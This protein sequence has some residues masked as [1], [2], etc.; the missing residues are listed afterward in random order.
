M[1][2]KRTP[3][4]KLADAVSGILEGVFEKISIGE[5]NAM[6]QIN[7]TTW[8]TLLGNMAKSVLT[9]ASEETA[10]EL[11]NIIFDTIFMNELSEYKVAMKKYMDM[12]KRLGDK[13]YISDLEDRVMQI[14]Q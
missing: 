9:N 12:N 8:K 14:A 13:E 1:A 4:D 6:R 5:L 2:S 3:V 7:G 11:G 10:T